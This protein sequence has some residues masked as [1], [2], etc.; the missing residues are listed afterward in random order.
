MSDRRRSKPIPARPPAGA[1]AKKPTPA[2]E[3]GGEP[4][5]AAPEADVA[6]VSLE[7]SDETTWTVRVLGRSGRSSATSPPLLLLGFWEGDA[8]GDPGLESLVV[9]TALGELSHDALHHALE[10]AGEPRDPDRKRPF[11]EGAGQARR[12]GR[13]ST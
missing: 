12:R 1:G 13:R 8:E 10:S 5:P 4:P 6:E 3:M 11:F 2:R 7:V 9:G